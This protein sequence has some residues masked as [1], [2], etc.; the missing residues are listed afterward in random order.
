[1]MK[2]SRTGIDIMNRNTIISLAMLYALW[3]SNRQDLLDLI[4]PF[5]LYAVGNTATVNAEIDISLVCDYMEKEFGYKS[6]Q[7]AVINRVLARESSSKVQKDY[8]NIEKKNRQFILVKSLSPL[9]DDFSTK[10]ITC[11]GHSDAVTS[12]LTNFLNEKRVRNRTDYI[13][14]EAERLLLSFFERQGGSIVLSVDDLRQ[15]T[16]R[17]NE[18]DF[19]IARFILKE[20][21]LKS[22]LFD[23]LVELVKGYF[24]T[25]ALYLQAENPNA[26]TASFSDVTFFLDTR[27][28]LAYLGYKT[29]EENIAY[30]KW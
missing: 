6:I 30:K 26:T 12:S 20:Y 10:R 5:V 11:K 8:R 21:E 28:L 17:S 3:Q 16:A 2:N 25:T 13:Q 18:V 7:V 15:L 14:A 9:I 4:R 24:V 1:M 29:E 23:Y 22:V 19:F 27:L